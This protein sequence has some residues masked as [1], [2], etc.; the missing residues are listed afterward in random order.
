MRVQYSSLLQYC[1]YCATIATAASLAAMRELIAGPADLLN[2]AASMN[3]STTSKAVLPLIG[4]L[5]SICL[6]TM[7]LDVFVSFYFV[8]ALIL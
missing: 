6:P 2:C 1:T 3:V 5:L 7:L 8:L 4:I